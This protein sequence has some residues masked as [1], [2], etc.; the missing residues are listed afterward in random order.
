MPDEAQSRLDLALLT[1]RSPLSTTRLEAVARRCRR[2]ILEMTTGA[3]SGHPGG[4]LS[5]IDLLVALYG[6]RLRVDPVQPSWPDRDRLVLSKGHASPAL[7]AVLAASGFLSVADLE[8]F[9]QLGQTCQGHVDA[10]WTP[11]VDFSGGSLGMGLS[12]GIGCALAARL[13]GS[14]RTIFVV[15][16]DGEVQEGEVW[17]AA[18]AA[19]HFTLGNLK[20]I[21][22][23]NRIQNDDFCDNQMRMGDLPAKWR[24]FGWAVK[25]I[26]GHRM[27][28]ILDGLAW[29][30][31]V[32]DGPA[33]LIAATVKG[34]GVSFMEMPRSLH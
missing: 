32:E 3:R 6:T 15:L 28:D 20:A 22:D 24:A 1:A 11:G 8:G 9:R 31:S 18:M 4:S 16:G 25:E 21:L 23:R 30:D 17:E 10:A 5:V 2:Q 14:A 13:D 29:L 27:D 26:D 7:Y 34:K 12:F 33:I 19:T